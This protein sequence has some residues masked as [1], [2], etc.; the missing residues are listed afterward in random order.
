MRS[1]DIIAEY[2][3]RYSEYIEMLGERFPE[4]LITKLAADLA[5]ERAK[6]TYLEKTKHVCARS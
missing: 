4:F 1:N 5:Q 3:D 2:C 6:N